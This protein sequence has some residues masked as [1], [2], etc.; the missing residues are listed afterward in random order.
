MYTH[1]D[2]VHRVILVTW[3]VIRF[4]LVVATTCPPSSARK[5][6]HQLKHIEIS[7]S[8]RNGG[9]LDI[10]NLINSLSSQAQQLPHAFHVHEPSHLFLSL[11][12]CWHRT[13][14]LRTVAV[15]L[16]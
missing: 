6:P 11:L 9:F 16:K 13:Y 15:T 5:H 2:L 3:N 1:C 7:I 14:I 4:A 10:S 8:A 12:F